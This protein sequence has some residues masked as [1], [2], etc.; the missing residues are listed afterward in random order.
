MPFLDLADKKKEVYDE[1][2]NRFWA[3]M[4]AIRLLTILLKSV[5]ISCGKPLTPTATVT[6]A[7]PEGVNLLHAR[8]VPALSTLCTRL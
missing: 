2:L 1:D 6:L 7:D 8:L 5:Q 4:V 3:S